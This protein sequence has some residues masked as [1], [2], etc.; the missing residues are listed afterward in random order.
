MIGFAEYYHKAATRKESKG[1]KLPETN[2]LLYAY[3]RAITGSGAIPMKENRDQV[4]LIGNI[5][6]DLMKEKFVLLLDIEKDL[7]SRLNHTIREIRSKR[8]YG[9]IPS[10]R[11]ITSFLG[12]HF[13]S[14]QEIADLL[15]EPRITIHQRKR[16][17]MI[18]YDSEPRYAD[19]TRK[20]ANK[21]G[22]QIKLT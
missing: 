18:Y 4:K 19:L 1:V 15:K 8:R 11:Q 12:S 14:E 9:D 13:L 16:K 3:R 6:D 20:V 7:C 10:I 17:A 5:K 22:I 21:F 2:K